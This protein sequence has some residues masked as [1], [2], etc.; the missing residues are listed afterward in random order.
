MTTTETGLNALTVT[1]QTAGSQSGRSPIIWQLSAVILAIGLA[2]AYIYRIQSRDKLQKKEL[3]LMQQELESQK[4]KLD[5]LTNAAY[6][7]KAPISLIYNPVKD[8]IERRNISDND[9]TVLKGILRQTD[10]LNHMVSLL[11]DGSLNSQETHGITLEKEYFN[12]WLNIQ[13]EDFRMRC[14]ANGTTLAFRPGLEVMQVTFDKEIVGSALTNVLD[15]AFKNSEGGTVTVSTSKREGYYR[16]SVKDQGLGSNG[17]T[18]ELFR[19]RHSNEKNDGN[20]H[21]ESG[22]SYAY[23]LIGLLGGHLIAEQNSDGKGSTY[24]IDIP[25]S[26]DTDMVNCGEIKVGNLNVQNVTGGSVSN[27]FDT[28]NASI[29]V[30]DDDTEMLN[31]IRNEYCNLFSTIYT[32]MDGREALDIARKKMPDVIVSDIIMPHMNGFTLC[33][34][35]KADLELGHIPVILLT[36]RSNTQNQETGYK[37]GADGFVPKPF[38]SKIMYRIISNQLKNR[39]EIK[40]QYSD[41]IFS[42]LD[43]EQTISHVDEMFILKL[44]SVIRDNLSNTNLNVSLIAEK[45]STSKTALFNKMNSLLNISASRYVK[46]IRMEAAKEM[47]SGTDMTISQISKEVGFTVCHYFSTV[48]K[49]YSGVSPR[50]YREQYKLETCETDS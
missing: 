38:D 18:S 37:M 16:I 20:Q 24:H 39:W 8:Y 45:M 11:I 21:D 19:N 32:A 17:Q 6:D 46:R 31:F 29:L 43:K 4:K 10:R 36:S 25:D 50:E 44:N 35:I 14:D 5:F 47:L 12:Q 48:F 41:A 33:Q 26:I 13:M 3:D 1:E 23:V 30:V 40:K 34:I 15:N 28:R 9:A 22:L 7:L 2:T 49:E 27:S 42:V